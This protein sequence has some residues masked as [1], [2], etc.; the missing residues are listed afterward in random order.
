[1]DDQRLKHTVNLLS[2]G[3][4]IGEITLVLGFKQDT[5]FYRFFKRMTGTSPRAYL[6]QRILT[7]FD[8]AV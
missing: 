8:V 1:L 7:D 5:Y 6:R 3:A 4:T 2:H